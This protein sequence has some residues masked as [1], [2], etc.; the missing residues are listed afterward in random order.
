MNSLGTTAIPAAT[1][2]LLRDSEGRP[3][4]LLMIER[5]STMA[6]A[7]G[8][9]VFPGGRVDPGDHAA[10][11]NRTVL[12]TGT[13]LDMDD[14]AARIAAIRETIEEVG[15]AVAIDPQPSH[16]ATLQIREALAE[17]GDFGALLAAADYR[18]DLERLTLFA[19]WRPN[20]AE[21]RIF[22]TRF[23]LAAAPAGAVGEA[24]G[25]ESVHSAWFRARAALAE[26]DVGDRHVIFPTRRNLERLAQF[27]TLGD[28]IGDAIRHP[29][30]MITPWVETRD[31][32]EW[33]CIPED[34][35]Y[36]VTAQLLATVRRS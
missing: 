23:Y 4:E 12:L 19:R 20:F 3:P 2:V 32:V 21:T 30:R 26:A 36:P 34:R 15:I 22:D 28:A 9:L 25:G 7:G 27:T 5:A 24:D 35:G 14:A 33:L 17:G 6:F 16:A 8:A 13:D 1:L 31:G 18:L 10:A 29:T 11:R